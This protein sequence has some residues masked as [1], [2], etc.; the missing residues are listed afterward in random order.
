MKGWVV[1]W[2]GPRGIGR[3]RGVDKREYSCHRSALVDVPALH[4]NQHVWFVPTESARGPRAE[5]VQLVLG[6]ID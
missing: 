5:H 2:D 3:V 6:V 1:S 4:R